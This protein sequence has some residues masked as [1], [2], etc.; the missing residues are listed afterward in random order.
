VQP[1]TDPRSSAESASWIEWRT[2]DGTPYYQNSLTRETAWE[3]PPQF[4]QWQSTQQRCSY[5]SSG[6]ACSE[7][8]RSD[9]NQRQ[10]VAT[11]P[12]Q[13][14]PHQ[15]AEQQRHLAVQQQVLQILPIESGRLLMHPPAQPPLSESLSALALA[16]PASAQPPPEWTVWKTDRG[17]PYFQNSV[18]GV[19]QW[20]PPDLAPSGPYAAH[21]APQCTAEHHSAPQCAVVHHRA[22]QCIAPPF[23]QC[24]TRHGYPTAPVP[25]THAL[26]T[27][28]ACEHRAPCRLHRCPT[29]TCTDR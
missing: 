25:H 21:R 14:A 26:S 5:G 20:D 27:L 22:L 28:S 2:E 10:L 18:T 17:V 23:Y 24:T 15:Q 1:A 7:D 12:T 6:A 19:V 9:G 13:L 4:R 11:A 29:C 16:P 3:L 8:D